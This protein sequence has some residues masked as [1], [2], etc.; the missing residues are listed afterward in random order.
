MTCQIDLSE[1]QHFLICSFRYAL[2][3]TTYVTSEMSELL[4]KY[5][6]KLQDWQQD[7]VLRHIHTAIDQ[8]DAGDKCDIHE[9]MKVI[10]HADRSRMQTSSK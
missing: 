6:D 2:G 3:R 5:W 7:Q 4:V 9:W 8:N 10:A 1:L